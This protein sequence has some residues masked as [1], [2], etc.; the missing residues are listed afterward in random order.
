MASHRLAAV[1][2]DLLRGTVLLQTW[3]RPGSQS[4][5]LSSTAVSA[6]VEPRPTGL[7]FYSF[8]RSRLALMVRPADLGRQPMVLDFCPRVWISMPSQNHPEW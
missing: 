3:I 1:T 6:R 8:I 2:A 7:A 5:F 4:G